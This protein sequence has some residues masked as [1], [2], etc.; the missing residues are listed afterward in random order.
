MK[1][2]SD[3]GAGGQQHSPLGICRLGAMV[4]VRDGSATEEWLAVDFS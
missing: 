3:A 4:P 2:R 1:V